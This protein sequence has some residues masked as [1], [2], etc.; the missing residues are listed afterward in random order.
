MNY[1]YGVEFLELTNGNAKEINATKGIRNAVGYH[2]NAVLSKWRITD[3]SI[4]R[5]HPLYGELYKE[6]TNG[7]AAGER[8][9]GGRMALFATTHLGDNSILLISVHS[10]TGSKKNTC[11][12]WMPSQCNK[13]LTW[14]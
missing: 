4:I 7:M 2:G 6:K 11:S 10:H 8:R 14:R 12:K 9:L 1:A 5:L 13:C 3:A